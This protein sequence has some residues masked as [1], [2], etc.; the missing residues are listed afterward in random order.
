M[1]FLI[2]FFSSIFHKYFILILFNTTMSNLNLPFVSYV[3]NVYY[4]M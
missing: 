1:K 2:T 3:P 4:D